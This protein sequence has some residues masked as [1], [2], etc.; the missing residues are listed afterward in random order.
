MLGSPAMAAPPSLAERLA[1][2]PDL[3]GAP[4]GL[5]V[6]LAYSTTDNFLKKDVYGDLERCYLRRS[7]AASLTRAVALLRKLRPD[8]RLLAYDC[9]RPLSVQ[10]AMW[11]MV[12]G[13]REQPYVA[14]PVRG[15]MHNLGCAID[16]TLS[17]SEGRPLDMGTPFDHAGP[18]AQPRLERAYV[19][20]G[21]LTRTQWA[22]RL[23]LR[24]VMT[25]AGFI[26]LDIEWWHFDCETPARARKLF[27][28]I[29]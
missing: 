7:A 10:R 18:L 6:R 16:L 5:L 8:L 29:R 22:N 21:K 24:Y 14:N 3:V 4:G 26:P 1:A 13:T 15:S 9:A 28:I 19:L 17:N 20:R 23:L 27:K 2:D 12:R 11:R 25:R